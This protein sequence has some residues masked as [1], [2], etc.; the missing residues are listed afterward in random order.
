MIAPWIDHSRRRLGTIPETTW[1]EPYMI[2]FLAM[3]ITLAARNQSNDRVADEALG[4]V[5]LQAWADITGV[6]DSEI[7]QEIC[8]LSSSRNAEFGEGCENALRFL[9]VFSGTQGPANPDIAD[10]CGT[11]EFQSGNANEVWPEHGRSPDFGRDG[12]LAAALWQR[13]FEEKIH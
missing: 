1:R 6:H 10:V 3:L 7:G 9:R 11:A 4:L 8:L 2:G 13:Y 5:Q 12:V